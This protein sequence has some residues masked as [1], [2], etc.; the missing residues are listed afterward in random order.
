MTE[1]N[2]FCIEIYEKIR[3]RQLKFSI[4]NN[5]SFCKQNCINKLNLCLEIK[6]ICI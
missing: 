4:C 5:I 3:Q 6:N 1:I 2:K